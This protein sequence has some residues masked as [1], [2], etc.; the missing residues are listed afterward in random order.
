M[1]HSVPPSPPC[2]NYPC[3]FLTIYFY[4]YDPITQKTDKDYTA[5][6][7]GN[8]VQTFPLENNATWKLVMEDSF[9]LSPFTCYIKTSD[10]G[11]TYADNCTHSLSKASNCTGCNYFS[12]P[13][14]FGFH[15]GCLP[16]NPNVNTY[17][18]LYLLDHR[19][20]NLLFRGPKPVVQD[21]NGN[22]IFDYNQFMTVL[23]KRFK[24]ELPEGLDGAGFPPK[25]LFVDISLISNDGL[26]KMYLEAENALFGGLGTPIAHTLSP[27]KPAALPPVKVGKIDATVTG[28]ILW[29]D[30]RPNANG[31][32]GAKQSDL[33]G[34]AKG[35][36][37]G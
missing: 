14:G 7:L 36:V 3:D 4:R 29:W 32:N 21:E 12:D 22:W 34:L 5:K 8:C 26:E 15:I 16:S 31:I 37:T 24:T 20:G 35:S 28:Q 25:F 23:Q 11:W 1:L 6:F 19:N 33:G 9:L 2:W 10:T 17:G 30:I 27:A 18:R 13:G